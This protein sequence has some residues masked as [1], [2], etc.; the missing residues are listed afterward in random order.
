MWEA[1]TAIATV[2]AAM[3]AV[4]ST[5]IQ[6][7]THFQKNAHIEMQPP[8]PLGVK[9]FIP[10]LRLNEMEKQN[11]RNLVQR[12]MFLAVVIYS[13]FLLP[14]TLILDSP[15]TLPARLVILGIITILLISAYYTGF[16]RGKLHGINETWEI[17]RKHDEEFA[18]HLEAS[19]REVFQRPSQDDLSR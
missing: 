4:V 5:Y 8:S 19:L 12:I 18:E 3:A 17:V 13:Y 11:I 14:F 1:V 16:F 2:I 6:A 7:R 10:Y 15:N 9:R